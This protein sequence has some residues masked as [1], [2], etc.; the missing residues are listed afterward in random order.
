MT[1]LNGMIFEINLCTNQ[2]HKHPN[3]LGSVASIEIKP[4]IS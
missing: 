3:N 1:L 4:L 2:T